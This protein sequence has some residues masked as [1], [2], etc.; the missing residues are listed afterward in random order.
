[1]PASSLDLGLVSVSTERLE[2]L[3]RAVHRE[4]LVCPL[5]P[6]GLAGHGLQDDTHALLGHLRGLDRA[7]VHAVVVAALA[8]RMAAAALAAEKARASA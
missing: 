3:L 1:M 4:T 2:I 6:A 8:E 7:G 5:T